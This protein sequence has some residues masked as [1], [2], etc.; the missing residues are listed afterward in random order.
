MKK[1]LKIIMLLPTIYQDTANQTLH[2]TLEWWKEEYKLT[3]DHYCNFIV[4]LYVDALDL[5]NPIFMGSSFGG[6]IALQLALKSSKQIQGS[7]SCR[8]SRSCTRILF[9]LVETSSCKCSTSMCKWSMGSYGS[10][11]T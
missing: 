4:K 7:Y 5:D 10:S 2:S 1:L 8:S 9:R 11:I 3:A 6:N